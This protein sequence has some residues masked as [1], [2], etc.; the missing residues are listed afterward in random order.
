MTYLLLGEHLQEQIDKIISDNN[1]NRESITNYDLEIESFNNVLIDI[2]TISLFESKKCI[3]C[4]NSNNIDDLDKLKDYLK[5]ETSNILILTM[6]A[7]N[8]NKKLYNLIDNK[9]DLTKIDIESY[10]KN[11]LKDYKI[12]PLNIR[13]II[14]N[15]NNNFNRIKNE[16]DKLKMYKFNEKEIT[17]DDI[18]LLIKKN[19]DNNIF[20]LIDNINKG[21]KKKS[22][23]IYNE[24]I[25]NNEAP[26]KILITLAN[27]YRLM[28]QVKELMNNKNDK[29]IMEMLDIKKEGR[30]YILKK[31]TYNFTSSKL[32]SIIK[33]LAKIDLSIKKGDLTDKQAMELFF[34]KI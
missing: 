11:E 29:E 16:L 6:K 33:E 13:L 18:N 32:L 19:L 14:T 10:I 30:L 2:N 7:I 21:N 25:K 20:D 23:E 15:C 17:S 3:I 34:T 27:N 31:Q 22:Y 12:T 1:I 5:H 28:Y 4:K 24:L 8:D 9:I 26:I